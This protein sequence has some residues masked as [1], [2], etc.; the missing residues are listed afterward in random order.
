MATSSIVMLSNIS[1]ERLYL[2]Q[3]PAWND[4]QRLPYSIA[5]QASSQQQQ[6]DGRS[7]QQVIRACYDKLLHHIYDM[8]SS[9][10]ATTTTI[11]QIKE[12]LDLAAEYCQLKTLP[13]GDK[14]YLHSDNFYLQVEFDPLTHL[15][16]NVLIF[17]TNE[18]RINEESL[19]CSR[20]LKALNDKQYRLFRAHLNGYASLFTLVAPTMN[21]DKRVGYTAYKVLQ[22]DLERLMKTEN[23]GKMLEG[24]QPICEGL[25]MRI[26]LNEQGTLFTMR[27]SDPS[28]H[29]KE[30]NLLSLADNNSSSP[31]YVRII[32]VPTTGQHY[33][34]MK[35]AVHIDEKS[36]QVHL[37]SS[38]MKACLLATGHFALEFDEKQAPFILLLSHAQEISRATNLDQFL[39]NA[40]PFNYLA[41]ILPKSKLLNHYQWYISHD[42]LAV[43]IRQI[44]FTNVKQLVQILGLLR[45][46]M[47]LTRYL[48]HYFHSDYEHDRME[49][50]TNS[51]ARDIFLE[52][53][54]LS[55][56]ILSITCAQS[57]HLSTFL[58]QM[59]NLE[60]FPLLTHRQQQ[61]EISL[62]VE[63]N[64]LL[65]LIEQLLQEETFIQGDSLSTTATT[66]MDY[67]STSVM[68][69]PLVKAIV[70]PKLNRRLSCGPPAKLAWRSATTLRRL[71]P[72]CFTLTSREE[73]PEKVDD[74]HITDESAEPSMMNDDDNDDD[75]F[76]SVSLQQTQQSTSMQ[77]Q[78]LLPK[79]SLSLNPSVLSRCTSVS[80]TQSVSTPPLFGLTPSTP[81]P[82]GG[83]NPSGN[84]FF[85]LAKQVSV[86][87][88][89]P[90]SPPI[91]MGAFDPSVFS[92]THLQSGSTAMASTDPNNKNQGKKKRRRSDHSAD[93]LIQSIGASSSG[94]SSIEESVT[95]TLSFRQSFSD[96]GHEITL[97]G[98]WCVGHE[99]Q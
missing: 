29:R 15:P 54:F 76:M 16:A 12:Q 89:N 96:A 63:K 70:I 26:K 46:Q 1:M 42:Q 33:L 51:R 13:D 98:R 32:I 50:D 87:D 79:P 22:Q 67:S 66:T 88:F 7:N 20:M 93:E 4:L 53:S 82:G 3:P 48:N 8:N 86:P 5:Q 84:I 65:K 71:Q 11:N 39:A 19:T 36:N 99:A 45:Q 44:P 35:S 41:K 52:L 31:S 68:Q 80:S 57:S 69:K 43:S 83:S 23:Y 60:A 21:N 75:L 17:F 97:V 61:K 94:R 24:F 74:D 30:W 91:S 40:K 14:V 37:E 18:Q 38:S 58:L 34:S 72:A 90:V 64:S 78:Q 9:V 95:F 25:P 10:S 49:D 85:P 77:H 6:Q 59:S 2:S 27:R 92:S 28:S 47:Y 55:S 73:Q 56:T 62:T 81:Y